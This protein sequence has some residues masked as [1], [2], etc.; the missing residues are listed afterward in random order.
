MKPWLVGVSICLCAC[1]PQVVNSTQNPPQTSAA[2][3]VLPTS[4]PTAAMPS[5]P[6][7]TPSVMA[8]SA[9]SVSPQPTA[10]PITQP[11]PSANQLIS[12]LELR[13]SRTYLSAQGE[14]SQLDVLAFDAQGQAVNPSGLD[15]Q[16]VSSKPQ[17]FSVD[18]R[19]R[20]TALVDHGSAEIQV[21]LNGTS[22]KAVQLI[23]VAR[24]SGS[25]GGG[26]SS[27]GSAPESSP[28]PPTQEQINGQI[29]FPF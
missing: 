12:R 28:T 4:R 11:M 7:A 6:S 15:F 20:V 17:Q 25:A 29:E 13:A 21:S 5:S 23:T 9:A 14:S 8:S 1:A 24:S 2:A 22:Q 16:F 27:G 3:S 10:S 19:G 26:G 18:A